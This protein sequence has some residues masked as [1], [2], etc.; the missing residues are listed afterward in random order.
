MN[1]RKHYNKH[2]N[3]KQKQ[4]ISL[5]PVFLSVVAIIECLMLITFTTYSWIESASSLIIT[6]EIDVN[7][8]TGDNPNPMIVASNKNFSFNITD[9]SSNNYIDLSS[10]YRDVK[11]YQFARA[12]SYDGKTIFFPR[13]TGSGD[14]KSTNLYRKGDTTDNNTSFNYLDLEITNSSSRNYGYV[15]KLEKE[16]NN[17]KNIFSVNSDSEILTDAIKQNVAK[18]F[19]ISICSDNKSGTDNTH[20]YSFEG[21]NTLQT[22]SSINASGGPTYATQSSRSI[23]NY[24]YYDS[25]SQPVGTLFSVVKGGSVK[26][27]VSIRIWLENAALNALNLTTEQ[28]NALLGANIDVNLKLLTSDNVKN[29][30]MFDDYTFSN[31]EENRGGHLTQDYTEQDNYR[32][33][34]KYHDT[35]KNKDYYYPMTSIGASTDGSLR[36]VT[37]NATGEATGTIDMDYI[38]ALGNTSGSYNNSYFY[39][40]LYD[41]TN[42]NNVP[43]TNNPTTTPLY[44][45]HSPN[46]A[47]PE[48]SEGSLYNAYSYTSNGT[49]PYGVGDWGDKALTLVKFRDQTIDVTDSSYNSGATYQFIK[50]GNHDTDM[51]VYSVNS[52]VANDYWKVPRMYYDSTNEIW[53]TYVPNEWVDENDN[54]YYRYCSTGSFTATPTVSFEAKVDSITASS[55]NKV[56]TGLGYTQN[57]LL[58][59]GNLTG[60]GT[61]GQTEVIKFSTELFDNNISP[62]NRYKVSYDGGTNYVSMKPQADNLTFYACIPKNYGVSGTQLKFEMLTAYNS[63]TATASWNTGNRTQNLVTYYPLV[64]NG[65]SGDGAWNVAVLVDAT[66]DNLINTTTTSPN[67]GTVTYS[68]DSGSS[69]INTNL[70]KIDSTRWAV[71]LDNSQNSILFKWQ[72][73]TNTEFTYSNDNISNKGIYCIVSE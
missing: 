5:I 65:A 31:K 33:V 46:R 30:I 40:G 73:Y 64:I 59:E 67:S 38:Q 19:R 66:Y 61:F 24:G 13:T 42:T 63:D 51:Y 39:Y 7:T 53:Q 70:V 2:R 68:V 9:S 28:L 29:T 4:V 21:G 1:K 56:F 45:W 44:T 20:I 36:W 47:L 72:P 49:T 16:G 10:Y 34:F 18:A 37:C 71:K 48:I 11:F 25:T 60:T 35:S 52:V 54:L 17:Y 26:T 15:F 41:L 32:M 6:D 57:K 27:F 62:N 22:V 69:Y 3:R 8:E 43:G 55:T 14:K 23:Q 58:S 50:I 12:S